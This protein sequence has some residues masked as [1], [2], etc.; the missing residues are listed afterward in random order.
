MNARGDRAGATPQDLACSAPPPTLPPPAQAPSPPDTKKGQ[1]PAKEGGMT[2][3]VNNVPTSAEAAKKGK[4][5]PPVIQVP[6][7]WYPS[8]RVVSETH[9]AS[10]RIPPTQP[11]ITRPLQNRT[12]TEKKQASPTLRMDFLRQQ[13]PRPMGIQEDKTCTWVHEPVVGW[14][15]PT[16]V[17]Q[18]ENSC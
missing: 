1:R 10:R 6:P 8:P 16:G 13:V 3:S 12:P 9:K 2:G 7:G 18:G 5:Q 4:R 17:T 14:L 15:V 11:P